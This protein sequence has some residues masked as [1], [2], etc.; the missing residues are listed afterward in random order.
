MK[1]HVFKEHIIVRENKI[2][3]RGEKV[4]K[5]V[6]MPKRHFNKMHIENMCTYMHTHTC[7]HTHTCLNGTEKNDLLQG[8]NMH[9]LQV[10]FGR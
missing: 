7:I 2:Y 3:Y 4:Q 8:K 9:F 1:N 10:P 6:D 5:L